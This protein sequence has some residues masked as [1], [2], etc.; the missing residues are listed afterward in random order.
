MCALVTLPGLMASQYQLGDSP[1]DTI[2]RV[3]N[4]LEQRLGNPHL[5]LEVRNRYISLHTQAI[6]QLANHMRAHTTH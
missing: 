1:L 2:C 5:L 3:I 4:F 6:I